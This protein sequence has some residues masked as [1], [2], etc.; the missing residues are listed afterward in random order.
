[1]SHGEDKECKAVTDVEIN[2]EDINV[3]FD[4]DHTNKIQVSNEIGIKFRDPSLRDLTSVDI[5]E[6]NYDTVVNVVAN[7]IDMVYDKEDVYDEFT[8]EESVEFL[9]SMTQDQFTKVQ[10]FFDTLP[11][12]KHTIT[13]TCPECGEKDSVTVEGLQNFFT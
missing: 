11:R 3:F 7:C 6:N 1:M 5:A 9:N 10:G 4:E 13:W 8:R 2:V 12:L